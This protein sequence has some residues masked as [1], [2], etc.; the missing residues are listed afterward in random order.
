MRKPQNKLYSTWGNYK[1][2]YTVHEEAIEQA[3]EC[4]KSNRANCKVH[5]EAIMQAIQYMRKLQSK[6]Y[7]T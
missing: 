7:I 1:V 4:M 2:S 5:E 3:V 6:L